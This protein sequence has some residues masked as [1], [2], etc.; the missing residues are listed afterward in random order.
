MPATGAAD[1]TYLAKK[2]AR[3]QNPTGTLRVYTLVW[4]I[5]AIA[6]LAK[7][8]ISAIN[9][10]FECSLIWL[11]ICKCNQTVKIENMSCVLIAGIH[12]SAK[13]WVS[14]G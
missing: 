14:H 10:I 1:N 8:A 11:Y 4:W 2:S 12:H 3:K 9:Q 13:V 6:N 5:Y 7:D